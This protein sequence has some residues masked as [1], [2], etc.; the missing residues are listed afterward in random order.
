M[1]M[2]SASVSADAQGISDGGNG[3]SMNIYDMAKFGMLYLNGGEWQGSQPA[4]R[5]SDRCRY[6]FKRHSA[7]F[8]LHIADAPV[9]TKRT[10]G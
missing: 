10:C 3:V 4:Q 5:G 6:G 9:Y 8:W 7:L 2:N 1:E